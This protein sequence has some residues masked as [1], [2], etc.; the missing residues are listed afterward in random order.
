MTA[1]NVVFCNN[2][3]QYTT[4]FHPNEVEVLNS[5]K[6]DMCL[7]VEKSIEKV[8][9]VCHLRPLREGIFF[10]LLRKN[11]KV[12]QSTLFCVIWEIHPTQKDQLVDPKRRFYQANTDTSFRHTIICLKAHD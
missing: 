4:K 8:A 12:K 5:W 9:L 2:G 11:Y 6:A 3:S 1:F 7:K 10:Q